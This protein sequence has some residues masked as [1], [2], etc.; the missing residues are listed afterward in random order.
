[1][2]YETQNTTDVKKKKLYSAVKPIFDH[3]DW[4][5]ICFGFKVFESD[6]IQINETWEFEPSSPDKGLTLETSDL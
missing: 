4:K 1:M 3:M 5:Y 6:C 2:D